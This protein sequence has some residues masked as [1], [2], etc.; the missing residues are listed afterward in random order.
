M[1][2]LTT[3]G[4]CSC[5]CF[6]AHVC[7][8]RACTTEKCVPFR[9][10]CTIAASYNKLRNVAMLLLKLVGKI[11]QQHIECSALPF[12]EHHAPGKA[13]WLHTHSFVVRPVCMPPVPLGLTGV[14]ATVLVVLW[15]LKSV[16]KG[17]LPVSH[18]R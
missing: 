7:S 2:F 3:R 10:W 18:A 1:A 12:S 15:L 5:R 4:R 14:L 16:C 8:F 11:K 6:S 17:V 13:H 9:K